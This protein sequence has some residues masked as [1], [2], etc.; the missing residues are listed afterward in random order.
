MS[1]EVQ[2]EIIN[3]FIIRDEVGN[4]LYD[5]CHE[6]V[7]REYDNGNSRDIRKIATDEEY[8]MLRGVMYGAMYTFTHNRN[9]DVQTIV[10]MAEI[11]AMKLLETIQPYNN[12]LT[13]THINCYD[14]VYSPLMKLFGVWG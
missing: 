9:A 7:V 4:L 8:R 13:E 10:D 5:L 3:D 12:P 1:I 6:V 11:T 2:R 14:T